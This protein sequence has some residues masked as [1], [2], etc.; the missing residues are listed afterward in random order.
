[1]FPYE[2]LVCKH[3]CCVFQAWCCDKKVTFTL[4][5]ECDMIL[6]ALTQW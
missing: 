5:A 6:K 2:S 4:Y 1:M 3:S